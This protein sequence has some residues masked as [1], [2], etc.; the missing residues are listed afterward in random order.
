MDAVRIEH[1]HRNDLLDLGDADLAAGHGRKIEV[2]AG[3]AEDEVAALVRLPALHHTEIG[4]DA[5][6]EDVVLAV[7]CLH[8]LALGDLSADPRLGVEA[9]DS[10][11]PCAHTF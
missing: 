7:E 1:A 6:L 8:F 9:G 2:A 3:L 4:T 5:A 11:S 10:R